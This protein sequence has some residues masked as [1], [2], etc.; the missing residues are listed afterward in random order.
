MS[1]VKLVKPVH[2]Y[3]ACVTTS[4]RGRLSALLYSPASST[5]HKADQQQVLSNACPSTSLDHCMHK[6]KNKTN[7]T[8]CQISPSKKAG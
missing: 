4:S 2:L 5:W 7:Q 8:K 3:L 1:F 6:N